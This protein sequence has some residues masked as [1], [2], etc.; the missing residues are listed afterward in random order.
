MKR[1]EAVKAGAMLVDS[2]LAARRHAYAGNTEEVANN[3]RM[4]SGAYTSYLWCISGCD[5]MSKKAAVDQSYRKISEVLNSILVKG[6]GIKYPEKQIGMIGN[7]VEDMLKHL[8]DM[9]KKSI[10]SS[11][12]GINLDQF[13]EVIADIVRDIGI[14]STNR[15][16]Y[17]EEHKLSEKDIS[18]SPDISDK[19]KE[20]SIK[21]HGEAINRKN[22]DIAKREMENALPDPRRNRMW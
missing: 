3:I 8:V 5:P 12:K 16:L 1:E 11:G 10:S 18:G 6:W 15:K 2:L 9:V 22:D 20:E 21:Q 17:N 19:M 13:S 4:A 14:I 7:K